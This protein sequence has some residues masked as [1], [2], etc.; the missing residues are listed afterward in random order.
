VLDRSAIV[1]AGIENAKRF[2]TKRALDRIEEIY[3]RILANDVTI[4]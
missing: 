1:N 4:G 3:L 2:D